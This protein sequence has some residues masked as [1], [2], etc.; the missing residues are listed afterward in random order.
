MHRHARTAC[1]GAGACA[2]WL[3]DLNTPRNTAGAVEPVEGG[4]FRQGHEREGLV[5]CEARRGRDMCDE[6]GMHGGGGGR[7]GIL[8]SKRAIRTLR[9]VRARRQRVHTGREG[10]SKE[11]SKHVQG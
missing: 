1:L 4:C 11:K 7:A 3:M 9:G 6:Q 8:R 5:A 10:R 2:P